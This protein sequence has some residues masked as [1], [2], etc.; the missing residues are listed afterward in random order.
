[1]AGIDQHIHVVTLIIKRE[2]DIPLVRSKAKILAGICG[3]PR[4]RRVE[5]A[6]SASE[7]ARFLL[8]YTRGGKAVFYI[9]CKIQAGVHGPSESGMKL[10]FQGKAGC[11]LN[12]DSETS[13]ETEKTFT[14]LVRSLQTIVDDLKFQN[15]QSGKPL[16]IEAV[17][18]GGRESCENLQKK[19]DQIKNLLFSDLEES[20]LENLRAKHEEVLALLRTLSQ[21][22]MELD[23]ANSELLELSQDMESLVHERTVV[24]LALRIADK[25]RN[26][27]TVIGGLAAIILK[28]I[29]EDFPQR[30]KI[31][32][33][34]KEALKLEAIV[35]DFEGLAREQ[36]RFF[37]VMDLRELIKETLDAW[38]PHLEQKNLKLVTRLAETPLKIHADP[39]VLKVAVLHVLKNAVYASPDDAELEVEVS[40]INGRPVFAI[41]DHGPGIP[42]EVKKKLFKG[43]VTTKPSGTGVGLIMVHHIMKEHQGEIEIESR[44][45][46]GTTVRLIFPERW[47]E[48]A[49]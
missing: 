14:G 31:E 9:V 41:R 8:H 12:T 37:T 27:A 45:G 3:F 11:R 16:Q 5:I 33:I 30:T 43:L 47:K 18:W 28:K 29:Q 1:M 2:R 38:Q 36:E 23:K 32:A 17:M 35:R 44:P 4:T 42:L 21:K 25:I 7:L 48:K 24:E 19:Y 49:S 22:N 13:S 20:F 6:L 15:C 40:R 39:R 46:S 10:G 26:P 34:F